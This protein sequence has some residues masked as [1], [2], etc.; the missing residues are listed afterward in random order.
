MKQTHTTHLRT[1][2]VPALAFTGMFLVGVTLFS[3]SSDGTL[4]LTGKSTA[5]RKQV[6]TDCTSTGWPNV[7]EWIDFCY[8]FRGGAGGTTNSGFT[9]QE[10]CNCPGATNPRC[11]PS[12]GGTG[13]GTSTPPDRCSNAQ[14]PFC[15]RNPYAR[16]C[17][18]KPFIGRTCE[19]SKC[20][21]ASDAWYREC[22]RVAS[23]IYYYDPGSTAA[24]CCEAYPVGSKENFCC[25]NPANTQCK[26]K[27]DPKKQCMDRATSD[28]VLAK[29]PALA[30]CYKAYCANVTEWPSAGYQEHKEKCRVDD[31]KDRCNKRVD[32]DS[33]NSTPELKKCMHD[34]C[35][36]GGSMIGYFAAQNN[37]KRPPPPDPCKQFATNF[38]GNPQQQACA[39]DVCNRNG[40]DDP[41]LHRKAMNRCVERSFGGGG[42]DPLGGGFGWPNG[43]GI[44]GNIQGGIGGGIGGVIGGGISGGFNGGMNG[45]FSGNNGGFGGI[46]GGGGG[47]VGGSGGQ[48]GQ[49]GQGGTTGGG[50]QGGAGG[51]SG[52]QSGGQQGG[53]S[54]GDVGG[55]GGDQGGGDQGGGQGG[56][57]GGDEGGASGGGDGGESAG[58]QG[59]DA[60]GSGGGQ[61][62]GASSGGASSG[63]QSSG[64]GGGL[65]LNPGI[66]GGG[67]EI[68]G[69]GRGATIGGGGLGRGAAI[70]G[71]GEQ[72][73]DPGSMTM[74]LQGPA[75]FDEF[76]GPLLLE[77]S[78]IAMDVPQYR[79]WS[80][81]FYSE[82]M[83]AGAA[84]GDDPAGDD[85]L[86]AAPS[87]PLGGARIDM[88]DPLALPTAPAAGA[89]DPLHGNFF[90]PAGEAGQAPDGWAELRSAFD[91]QKIPADLSTLLQE[92]ERD[93][94]PPS[95]DLPLWMQ[96]QPES[97]LTE[98]SPV[99]AAPADRTPSLFIPD[100]PG[101][102]PNLSSTVVAAPSA[103][104]RVSV[105][106]AA[107][108]LPAPATG[109][110]TGAASPLSGA[111]AS[112]AGAE[113]AVQAATRRS[114]Q[115]LR[116]LHATAVSPE[117][118]RV[119]DAMTQ[120][121]LKIAGNV[122]R[123][124]VTA[125]EA[126]RQLNAVERDAGKVL[127]TMPPR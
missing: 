43:G 31:E 102:A 49:G 59:G 36:N 125:E 21:G 16:E 63:G 44:G 88:P 19:L 72:G 60:G 111:S 124:T 91:G 107:A 26:P 56:D 93:S 53:D 112:P 81:P 66:T 61:S 83:W 69:R 127:K 122:I 52:G 90:A 73:G 58:D 33:G 80:Q 46:P 34:Y 120:K 1:W 123:G 119:A 20:M 9:C 54:G 45:G 55:S 96:G 74:M 84:Q 70:G 25:N 29:N 105:P 65:W 89:D 118:K 18:C 97:G 99:A 14:D 117:Q 10:Y 27:S 4:V 87:A 78:G 11:T 28:G 85:P 22:N 5:E 67:G 79:S 68:G 108:P 114:V 113:G 116:S 3:R 103:L 94:E 37:C 40:A 82:D 47:T 104:P 2:L 101:P 23:C 95:G 121:F 48:G 39:L 57:S 86:H 41:D 32:S 126:T 30:A 24:Q 109:G 35:N 100:V 106:R 15:C 12:P 115:S 13:A 64:G 76:L 50:S 42:G 6:P 17:R 62:S 77:E 75:P 51:T 38:S 98:T 7:N 8:A 92:L 110:A 71:D